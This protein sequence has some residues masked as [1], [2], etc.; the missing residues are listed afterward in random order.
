[1]ELLDEKSAIESEIAEHGVC[2]TVTAGESMRP[3]FRTHKDAVVLKKPDREFKKY[4]AVLYKSPMGRYVL[5]RVIGRR[6]DI[7]IIRG[8]NTYKKEYVRSDS[9]IAYMISFNRGGKHYDVD[10]RGYKSYCI[11]W[12][13]IYPVRYT[14]HKVLSLMRWMKRKI[15]GKKK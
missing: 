7:L 15:F 2:A 14:V 13:F 8:D 4:D 5:H 6:G 9:V 3:L 12:N 11:L 1:M 10:S